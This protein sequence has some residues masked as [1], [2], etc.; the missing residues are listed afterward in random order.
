MQK[1]FFFLNERIVSLVLYV[2]RIC[3]AFAGWR[4]VSMWRSAVSQSKG[5][6][7]SCSYILARIRE[8]FF[9]VFFLAST[10]PCYTFL[11]YGL[12]VLLS[13]VLEAPCAAILYRP[14]FSGHNS[15]ILGS[16]FANGQ[17]NNKEKSRNG[18]TLGPVELFVWPEQG[19][20]E[21]WHEQDDQGEGRHKKNWL[22]F[23]K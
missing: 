19:I 9:S 14:V 21:D 16:F 13:V 20:Q 3:R 6:I 7:N 2:C 15:S 5:S 23:R 12:E 8:P 22:F 4:L 10:E 11:R 1:N 17:L 18:D